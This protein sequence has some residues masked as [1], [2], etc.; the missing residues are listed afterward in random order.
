M[1]EPE[2]LCSVDARGVATVRLNRPHR[3]NAY[4]DAM[5]RGLLDGVGRLADDPSH[6]HDRIDPRWAGLTGYG[7]D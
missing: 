4:N 6:A 2:V 1:S 7:N 5:L 3:N